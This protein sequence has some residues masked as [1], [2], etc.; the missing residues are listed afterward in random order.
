MKTYIRF[1]HWAPRIL[2][3]LAILLVSMFAL[4]VFDPKLTVWQQLAAF[5]LHLI[6]SLFLFLLLVIAWKWELTGGIIFMVI[7]LGL[8]P[9]LFIGNYHMNHSVWLSLSVILLITFPF[10]VTGGLFVLSHFLKKK[11]AGRIPPE[12]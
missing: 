5:A 6:P 9:S 4:D 8:S 12:K 7:A 10:F 2:C 3:I 11:N 1:F